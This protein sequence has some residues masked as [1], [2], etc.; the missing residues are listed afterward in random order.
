[1]RVPKIFCR[2]GCTILPLV[3]LSPA[4]S[5]DSPAV[6]E[7]R[8][9]VRELRASVAQMRADNARYRQETQ[10][11]HK[12]LFAL[13]G[14]SGEAPPTGYEAA[15][16]LPAESANVEPITAAPQSDGDKTT[17]DADH[18][19]KLDEEYQLLSSKV[20]EH[21][22][23]KVESASKYRVRL[24]GIVL[25]NLFANKGRVENQDFPTVPLPVPVGTP[26]G[27]L[28]ATLR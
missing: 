16:V 8:E 7:L 4:W 27:S 5:Q 11:M 15:T 22:Q 3:L 20:D 9:E 26:S 13:R 18:T 12:E 10:Q 23:S 6:Q 1:M 14:P 19:A 28:G 25:L 21:Y 24:S 17:R 2:L